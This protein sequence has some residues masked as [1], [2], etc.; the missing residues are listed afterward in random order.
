ML[1]DFTVPIRT[2][3]K[4]ILVTGPGAPAIDSIADLSGKTVSVLDGSAQ[5]EDVRAL[6][7]AFQRRRAAPVIVQPAPKNFGDQDLLEMVNAGLVKAAIVDDYSAAFWQQILPNLRLRP[8]IAIGESG[9]LA[10]AVRKG[11][12]QFLA[13]LNPIVDAHKAGTLWGNVTFKTYLRD[14]R[15]VLNATDDREKQRFQNL[16]GI[17]R[18][19]GERYDVDY[20]LLMA[21]GYQE[22]RLD[23]SA[24]SRAGAAG[25]MQ[26]MPATARKM[27]VG[28]VRQ[29]DANIHAGVKYVRFL[30]DTE[31]AGEP[32]GD[33]TKTLF[34]FAAYNCGPTRL[35][36]LR[37]EAARQ[38][39]DPD[40]WFG[41]VERIAAARLGRETVQYVSNIYKYY[42]AY[43]STPDWLDN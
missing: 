40:L 27:K 32:I 12:P 8:E 22:S 5:L 20:L 19:Y 10:W 11:S 6:N 17:F 24:T 1:V 18:K 23:H 39:L 9:N 25:I 7:L 35:R 28:D 14:T 29:L 42:L 13:V 38:G 30:L 3:V 26:V 15:F 41:H 2:G 37:A 31:F 33:V 21:Q 36:R 34:A 16:V 4:Q 43:S